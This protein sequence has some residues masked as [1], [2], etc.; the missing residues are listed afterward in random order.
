MAGLGRVLTAGT[1]VAI[2]CAAWAPKAAAQDVARPATQ[3][4]RVSRG[5]ISGTVSDVQGGP[6]AG[7]V[8]S[9]VGATMAMAIT[10]DRGFFAI[11]GLPAGE[12]ILQAHLKG[13]EGSA[14]ERVQIGLTDR[15]V[16]SFRLTP[17]AAAVGT[18]GATPVSARPIMAA[19]LALPGS[20]LSDE[21]DPAAGAPAD[22]PHTETAWRLRHIPRSVLKDTQSTADTGDAGD[23]EAEWPGTM[24]WRAADAL[25]PASASPLGMPLPFSGEV[26]LLTTSAFAPGS[27]LSDGS[28]PRGVAYL[29]I[30]APTPAG[31]WSVRAALTESDV[32]SWIVA[33]A[34]A[35]RPGATH[36]YNLGLGY[37]VQ[38]YTGGNPVTL[39]AFADGS[40]NVG[41]LYGFD[42]WSVAPRL[43]LEY[44]A[45]YAHY[46][47][48]EN[49]N[50][51]SP[52]LLMSVEPIEN[53][54]VLARVSQR[55]VAPGAEEFLSR[56]ASGPWLP[57]ERTFSALGGPFAPMRVERAR[58]VALGLEH[59]FK[60]AGVIGVE[61]VV[62]R[63]DDQLA[64]IFGVNLA[65][66]P[67]STGHYYVATAGSLDADGWVFRASSSPRNRIRGAID[68]SVTHTR[69]LDNA[70]TDLLSRYAPT[71]LRPAREDLHD[72]TTSVEADVP[73]TAT[74]VFVLYKIN[75]GFARRRAAAAGAALDGRFDLQINQAI[76]FDLA[77][78]RWELLLGVRNLFRDPNDPAS[79]YDEILVLQA[80]RRVVGG[81][82][83][84]F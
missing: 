80:P 52:R 12:Y 2:A 71:A 72:L 41:E 70:E 56:G 79:V 42:R 8:I 81:V 40:R 34:F 15:A 18:T 28:V 22:H 17:L 9:A 53:T 78:T 29:A 57:P 30:G 3:S 37:A 27:M 11:D 62:Q 58:T 48:L 4:A 19:G 46:D 7:A 38:D 35:S 14:R 83:V 51:L 54:R 50:L 1:L 32:S 59:E 60:G 68:Y 39:A 36:A 67:D 74:R 77:G 16:R 82:L 55:M 10:D 73:E 23:D 75:S 61:R 49:R 33:G 21:P 69:W 5:S 45:Q 63:V 64:T 47:Y 20:T 66:N 31:D 6:L 26:N 84:R 25:S 24:L 44:G 13:F 76:P 65:D 43:V